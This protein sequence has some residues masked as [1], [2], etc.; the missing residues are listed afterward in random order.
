MNLRS[1]TTGCDRPLYCTALVADVPFKQG[2]GMHG[3]F[4]RADTAN[5]MAAIGPAFRRGYAD[6]A[7]VSNADI[8]LTLARLIGVDLPPK[9]KLTGRVITEALRNGRLVRYVRRSIVSPPGDG[10]LRTILNAQYVGDTPYF[11][12]AGFAGRTV[13]LRVPSRARAR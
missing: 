9:G 3:S 12:A 6:P 10:G 5:F 1:Y 13:G 4:S 11:D 2:Q 8:A 7:P